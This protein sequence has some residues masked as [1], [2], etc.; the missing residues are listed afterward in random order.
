MNRSIRP[1][2]C[3]AALGTAALLTL[4]ACGNQ[5]DNSSAD[6][7]ASVTDH[8]H[9]HDHDSEGGNTG[10]EAAAQTPRI[11]ITYDGG[12]AVLDAHSLETEGELELAGFNRLSD[13]G[14]GRHVAV[15]TTGG[16]ALLDAGTWSQAHGD[17]SHYYT[18]DPSL[19]DVIVEAEEPGHVVVHDGLV[20]L[21]DDGSGKTTVVEASGWEE[22]AEHGHVHPVREYT[23]AEPHHGVAVANSEDELL[24]TRGNDE[25]RTGA[26]ILDKDDNE[27]VANDE[28]P[29]VHGETAF[30]NSSDEASIVLGCE[31]GALVFHGDHAHKLAAPDEFGRIGNAF[32]SD[33]SDV[34]LGDY[35]TD[36]DAGLGL[37]Q[38]ALIDTAADTITPVD[39][40]ADSDAVYTWRGLGRG[41]EG[42]ILVLGTDGSLRVLDPATGEEQRSIKV[43]DEWEVPEE[44][45][46]AHPA[47]IELAGMAYVTDPANKT[48]HAVDYNGGEVWK[49][50]EVG[51][52]M[53]EVV[54]VT[55]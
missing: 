4:S 6:A 54:G 17:H 19:S 9:D 51:V 33:G 38:I 42:E 7:S 18:A 37:E 45:Q 26:M 35:K 47:L 16:W 44:W 24:V 32:S 28:C 41:G 20:A 40:F 8:D 25:E 53:N 23:A 11:A 27:I 30:E 3:F 21:F 15:S 52:E 29:G 55:G 13:A 12:V 5:A 10:T 49:S 43:I 2:R 39:P 34:V 22:A 1:I 36:P 14:D 48:I 50:V 46:T 31:D